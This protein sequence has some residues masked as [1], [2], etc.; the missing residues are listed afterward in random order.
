[1]AVSIRAE[2]DARDLARVMR[3]LKSVDKSLADDLKNTIKPALDPIAKQIGAR[4]NSTPAPMSGMTKIP[5]RNPGRYEW[6]PG[7]ISVSVTPGFSFKSPNLVTIRF[8]TPKDRAGIPIA[9]NAGSKSQGKNIQGQL[10]IKR[11]MTVVEGWP[12]GGRF[13][14][15]TF[16]PYKP[17]IYTL[18]E[19]LVIR[20][21]EKTNRE[22]ESR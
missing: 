20:W 17:H 16:M 4:V 7:R 13:L 10:F 3:V 1:M 2:V 14:Y 11:I 18:A 6:A 8:A 9:E 21:T 5:G 19:N 15:R 22:L 12:N